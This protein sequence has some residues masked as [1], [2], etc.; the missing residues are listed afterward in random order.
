MFFVLASLFPLSALGQNYWQQINNGLADDTLIRAAIVRANGEI[1]IGTADGGY[2][3]TNHGT[4]WVA[5]VP[6]GNITVQSLAFDKDF[7]YA[8]TNHGIFVS[9][10]DGSNWAPSNNGFPDSLVTTIGLNDS[11]HVYAGV[12]VGDLFR[13][14]DQGAN[15]ARHSAGIGYQDMN[16]FANFGGRTLFMGTDGG[17]VYRTTNNGASWVYM[18]NGLTDPLIHAIA[19]KRSGVIF[20][21]GNT[22]GVFRSLDTGKT[23][24]TVNT[25]LTSTFI[26]ALIVHPNGTVY[27]GT[28]GGGVFRSTDNGDHWAEINAGLTSLDVFAFAVDSS[29]YIYAG[30]LGGMFRSINPTTSVDKVNEVVPRSFILEQNFPNPFNPT[31]EIRYAIRDAGFVTLKIYDM[32]GSEVATLVN[33]VEGPGFK[34]VLYDA[35]R[36]SSGMYIYR[37][38]SGTFTDQKKLMLIK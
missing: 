25:N 21:G 24:N 34:S 27:A 28:F 23:W 35:S 10:D 2:K 8:G 38:T 37:I 31:T 30:T 13:S 1:F 3:S 26:N 20:A 36:L 22:D 19:I 29:G 15:W 9:S 16:V 5:L 7:V 17:G 32:L 12:D 14:T 11:G 18:S 33:Q 4:S 6:P